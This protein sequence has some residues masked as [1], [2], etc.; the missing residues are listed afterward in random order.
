MTLSFITF[1]RK[2]SEEIKKDMNDDFSMNL[3]KKLVF[4]S[5]T[6]NFLSCQN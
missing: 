1:L 3:I 5:I 2:I 4:P 6:R